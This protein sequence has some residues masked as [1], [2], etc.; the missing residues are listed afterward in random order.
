MGE[1]GVFQ[2]WRNARR[3]GT[4]GPQLLQE[5][6]EL[7]RLFIMGFGYQYLIEPYD[8]LTSLQHRD[9][10]FQVATPTGWSVC[11]CND[12]M[13]KEYLNASDEYL[14]STAPIQGVRVYHISDR[15]KLISGVDIVL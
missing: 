7:V 1:R 9:F 15:S 12:A 11:I 13:I 5:G 10:A 4:C 3:W 8:S 14:S 6:Y 2:Y